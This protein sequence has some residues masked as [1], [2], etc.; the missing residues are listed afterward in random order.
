MGQSWVGLIDLVVKGR[1]P[2]SLIKLNGPNEGDQGV[3]IP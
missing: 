3:E 1:D 2:C